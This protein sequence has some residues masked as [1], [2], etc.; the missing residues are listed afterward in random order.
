LDFHYKID[1]TAIVQTMTSGVYDELG[2]TFVYENKGFIIKSVNDNYDLQY[3]DFYTDTAENEA[4]R[5]YL[6]IVYTPP[7][8]TKD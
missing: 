1:V 7:F 6:K 2:D 5:P 8:G 3:L 4:Y